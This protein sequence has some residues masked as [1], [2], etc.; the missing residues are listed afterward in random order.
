[1]AKT[2]NTG[3]AAAQQPALLE[4]PLDWWQ[5]FWAGFI[6]ILSMA[7]SIWLI[8]SFWPN[9]MPTAT[10]TVYTNNFPHITL[11]E[12]GKPVGCVIQF[13]A[14]VLM[15][16]AFA[17]FLGNLVY[18]SASLTAYI[19]SG[20]FRRSWIPWYFVKPFT[21]SGLAMFLYLAVN[22]SAL[23]PP[24]NLNGIIAAAAL[25]GL[26]TDIATQKLKEIFTAMFKPAENLP[27]KITDPGIKP[28]TVDL[29]AMKP[30][31][32]DTTK[33]ND[34][35]IPGQRLDEKNLLVTINDVKITPLT[36]TPTLLKFSYTV[37]DA[38]K[39]K[40]TL[41]ITDAKGIKIDK[42]DLGV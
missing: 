5:K 37:D 23:T 39:T 40:F 1:M 10:S 8:I 34:F 22:S 26:F 24:V 32:I 18:V 21:A 27:N 6:L 4:P 14:L 16:V 19:G 41:L 20:R 13:N 36:V 15:L 38:T 11:I 7:V 2:I 12:D 31:K 42:K 35:E 30:Q 33:A 25:A 3:A 28:P 29:N 17:G 9:K